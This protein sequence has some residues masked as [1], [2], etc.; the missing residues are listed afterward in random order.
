[1]HSIDF[2]FFGFV[3]QI[4]SSF[5]FYLS[6]HYLQP[7]VPLFC[8]C[9]FV[10]ENR[11]QHLDHWKMTESQQKL[12]SDVVNKEQQQQ[13]KSFKLNHNQMK[14]RKKIDA[15]KKVFKSRKWN[16]Y[17]KVLWLYH[18]LCAVSYR[19]SKCGKPQPLIFVVAAIL[20]YFLSVN[21]HFLRAIVILD[22]L[23]K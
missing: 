23:F 15:T 2:L 22:V 9:V 16:I 21:F 1:M 7:I 4:R 3:L 12:I 13:Q 17:L 14:G 8:V 5:H 18:S 20:T 19:I 11:I 10:C 6:N